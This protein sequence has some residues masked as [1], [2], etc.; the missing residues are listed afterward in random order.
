MKMVTAT[1]IGK[2]HMTNRTGRTS[3]KV[4]ARIA[5]ALY[6]L[7]APLGVFGIGYVPS[8]IVAGDAAATASNIMASESLYRLSIVAALL[9]QVIN[10]LVVL[11][12]YR[13]LRPAHKT[14]PLLMVVFFLVSV[15]ITMLNEVNHVAP[16]LLLNNADYLTVFTADQ[17][18]A[19]VPLFLDLHEYG[20]NIASIFWGLWLFP[21][22]YAVFKSGYLPKIL[23]ILLMIGC[24]GYL[25]DFVLFTLFPT[26]NLTVAQFT[27]IGELLLPL[28]LLIKGVNVERWEERALEAA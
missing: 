7:I 13:V 24:V 8:L 5:G 14:M 15:P 1:N 27:F 6:L 23:G 10:I 2:M 22:G 17:L 21:M 19:L 12:L 9:T 18:Q 16:L 11:A 20:V 3:P 28:W 26:V 4:Y 25:A